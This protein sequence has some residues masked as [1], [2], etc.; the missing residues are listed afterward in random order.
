M[1]NVKI[2]QYMISDIQAKHDQLKSRKK[3]FCGLWFASG[4]TFVEISLANI[5]PVKARLKMHLF[6]GVN[7]AGKSSGF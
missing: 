3:I 7:A 6:K 5:E 1:T 4:Q 2:G